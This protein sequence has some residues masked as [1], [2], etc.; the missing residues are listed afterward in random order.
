[1]FV[2][3]NGERKHSTDA[4]EFFK[5]MHNFFIIWIFIDFEPTTKCMSPTS[6]EMKYILIQLSR[7]VLIYTSVRTQQVFIELLKNE[8][9]RYSPIAYRVCGSLPIEPS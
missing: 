8:E 4:V 3:V 1:M 6:I 5:P 2:K 9:A 7:N